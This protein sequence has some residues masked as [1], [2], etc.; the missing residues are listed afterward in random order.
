MALLRRTREGSVGCAASFAR[1]G[2]VRPHPEP[3]GALPQ[4]RQ[5]EAIVSPKPVSSS[6]RR[7]HFT[8]AYEVTNTDKSVAQSGVVR[9]DLNLH[10]R[11]VRFLEHNLRGRAANREL[12]RQAGTTVALIRLLSLL[13]DDTWPQKEAWLKIFGLAQRETYQQQLPTIAVTLKTHSSPK[14][15]TCA[16]WCCHS[17]EFAADQ[18]ATEVWIVRARGNIASFCGSSCANNGKDALNT[19]EARGAAAMISRIVVELLGHHS[20]SEDLRALLTALAD[21]RPE[22]WVQPLLLKVL[23]QAVA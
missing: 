23:A 15:P 9:V 12:A 1:G 7:R 3:L 19:P 16:L 14:G 4:R 18:L 20:S 13:D 11:V 17:G 21:S 5:L 22:R 6:R 8:G 2:P 10:M